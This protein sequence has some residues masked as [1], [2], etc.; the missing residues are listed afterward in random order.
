M[1]FKNRINGEVCFVTDTVVDWV[2]IFSRPIYRHII[3]NSLFKS[4]CLENTHFKPFYFNR[5]SA[6]GADPEPL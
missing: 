5:N 1:E 2:D 4:T 6:G 3:T